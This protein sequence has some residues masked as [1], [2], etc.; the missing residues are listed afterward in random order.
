M[1]AAPDLVLPSPTG[2]SGRR[3]RSVP[4]W[5]L[6]GIRP[7][8]TRPLVS[9]R[10]A[11]SLGLAGSRTGTCRG[12]VARDPKGLPCLVSRAIAEC[13][14]LLTVKHSFHHECPHSP[15]VGTASADRIP[16]R[17]AKRIG[18]WQTAGVFERF[19]ERAREVV[20]LAQDEA[21]LFGHGHIGT[22]HLLLGLV[23]EGE[24]IAAQVFAALDVTEEAVRGQVAATVGHGDEGTSGALPFTPS[25][26]KALERAWNEALLLGH[27]SIDTQHILLGLL[28]VKEGVAARILLDFDA[29]ADKVRAVVTR[30]VS[31]PS[32]AAT[33]MPFTIRCPQCGQVLDDGTLAVIEHGQT[34]ASHEGPI[35][36][37]SCGARWDLTYSVHWQPLPTAETD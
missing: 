21:R 31:K 6:A 14:C 11:R 23:R 34:H 37:S 2:H 35:D 32:Q 13:S 7:E 19:T 22:E 33:N 12:A 20:A 30:L 5:R 28:R 4:S 15:M 26:T 18:L 1:W 36:C 10:G 29:D 8:T 25:G 27:T 9:G 24:G 16:G 3:R 17:R